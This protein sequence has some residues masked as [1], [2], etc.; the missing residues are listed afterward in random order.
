MSELLKIKYTLWKERAQKHTQWK[1]YH[2]VDGSDRVAVTGNS[3]H[4]YR[5]FVDED[6]IAD[7]NSSFPGA[8]VVESVDEA[9]TL[10][11]GDN[12][13][14]VTPS[15]APEGWL[16]WFA[17]ADDDPSPP[18]GQVGRGEGNQVLIT[19]TQDETLTQDLNFNEPIEFHD[20]E[21]TWE[22]ADWDFLDTFSFSVIMPATTP[23]S[24]AGSGNCNRVEVAPSTGM[25]ILIPAAGNG[26]H[27]VDLATAI[28]VPSRGKTGYYDVD[29]KTGVVTVSTTP[30]RADFDL[31]DF[32]NEIYFL[33]RIG[34]GNPLGVFAIDVYKTDWVSE[35]WTPRFK[36]ERATTGS[37]TFRVGAWF[38][39]YR[40]GNT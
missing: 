20:G 19:C 3:D 17:G 24:N 34:M 35:R 30:G 36:V 28:P 21:V 37:G 9:R 31:Y 12:P 1:I 18:A 16:T 26:S 29:R 8:V 23:T 6:N 4:Q 11:I 10:L 32:Q 14:V 13:Q 5:T 33:K 15:P 25:H 27:D 2:V 38:F 39:V 7:Y 40:P 22:P